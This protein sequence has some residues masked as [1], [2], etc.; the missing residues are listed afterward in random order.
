MIEVNELTRE[1]DKI[2]ENRALELMPLLTDPSR[3]D[4]NALAISAILG[5]AVNYLCS[6]SRHIR[7]FNGIDLGSETGWRQ[8]ERSIELLIR[9]NNASLE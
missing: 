6:R 9:L 7:Y 3:A 1:L 4:P 8:L 2:R 5:A